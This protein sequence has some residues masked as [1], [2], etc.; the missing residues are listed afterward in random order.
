MKTCIDIFKELPHLAERYNLAYDVN[1]S[2][3]VNL[4]QKKSYVKSIYIK[5][6]REYI[7]SVHLF[8][9]DNDFFDFQCCSIWGLKD[10]STF[11][12]KHEYNLSKKSFMNFNFYKWFN[13]FFYHM[14]YL[15]IKKEKQ[16]LAKEFEI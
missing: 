16:E 7:L 6:E 14:K 8:S 5:T 12:C 2:L 9:L 15:K 13:G 3:V 10:E 4:Q 1:D 11:K